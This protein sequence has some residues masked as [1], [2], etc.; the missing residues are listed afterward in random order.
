MK[1]PGDAPRCEG[2]TSS[3]DKPLSEVL[4]KVL[5][6]MT[7]VSQSVEDSK[8]RCTMKSPA[9]AP[10][11]EG[12]TSSLD[13]PLSEERFKVQSPGVEYTEARAAGGGVT[14]SSQHPPVFPANYIVRGSA[15]RAT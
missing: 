2:E 6:K 8:L 7:G 1:S 12:D 3:L 10:R 15:C 4:F 14:A 9:D 5:R 13:K 11:C